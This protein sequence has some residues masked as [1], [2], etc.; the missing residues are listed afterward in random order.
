M[1][2]KLFA[3]R[4]QKLKSQADSQKRLS[5]LNRGLDG[6]DQSILLQIRH[7]ITERPDSRQDHM[8]G[9][10]NRRGIARDHRLVPHRLKG[11]GDTTK[12]SHPVVDNG[13]HTFF[14]PKGS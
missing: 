3:F 9:I 12:V 8:T 10:L 6:L 4:K 14:T 7:A 11:L 5:R 13:N 2:A 1:L